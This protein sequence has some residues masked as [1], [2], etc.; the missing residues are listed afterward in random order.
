MS[1]LIKFLEL[2]P[3]RKA[4]SYKPNYR[5]ICRILKRNSY[6]FRSR[7]HWGQVLENNCYLLTSNFLYEVRKIRYDNG[8]PV[9][10]IL[11]LY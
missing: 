11:S 1:L 9:N 2:V 8:I 7:T 6:T 5:Y 3:E 4:K 10:S